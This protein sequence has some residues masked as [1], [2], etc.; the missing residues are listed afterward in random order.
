MNIK[1][2]VEGMTAPQVA[3]VIKDNFN[4]VDKDKA[5]KTDVNASIAKLAETVETN[6]TETD[7]KIDSNKEET[8]GK[9][10]ELGSKYEKDYEP[11]LIV[12]DAAKG[13]KVYDLPLLKDNVYVLTNKSSATLSVDNVNPSNYDEKYDIFGNCVANMQKELVPTANGK[14]AVYANG[15]NSFEVECLN[16]LYY[17]FMQSLNKISA[18]AED[19]KK[20]LREGVNVT[21]ESVLSDANMAEINKI[22]LLSN[23]VANTPADY[24][25]LYSI[26]QGLQEYVVQYL[27]TP[28]STLYYRVKWREWRPWYKC[29]TI[30]IVL[31]TFLVHTETG[32]FVGTL[33]DGKNAQVGGSKVNLATG[34]VGNHSC[35]VADVQGGDTLK[36]YCTWTGNESYGCGWIAT[37][38]NGNVVDKFYGDGNGNGYLYAIMPD[39]ASKIY[40]NGLNGLVPTAEKTT[41]TK[42]LDCYTREEVDSKLQ[43]GVGPNISLSMFRKFGVVGDSYAS[44]E[45]YWKEGSEWKSKDKY[46]ISWGQIL[47][48]KHG[49]E[50]TN[51]SQGGLSTRTWLYSSTVNG[52]TKML[53]SEAEDLYILALGIN[54]YYGLGE[55]YLGTINDITTNADTFYGNYGQI[56]EQIKAHAPYAKLILFTCAGDTEIVQKFNTAIINIANHYGIPHIVQMEDSFFSSDIYNDMVQGH[57]RGV[58]YCGMANAFD[59]LINDC[60]KNNYVY[61]KDLYM[62]SGD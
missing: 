35:L 53:N 21:S 9:L 18:N 46:S 30:D 50:C 29:S 25:V 60:L 22:Y 16:S 45:V 17:K 40:V 52:L 56:I 41:T 43:K 12:T 11:T 58:A 44:G 31:P 6:K 37:D 28:N 39:N 38:A 59:R 5:N 19:I 47:A 10:S 61:F 2:I 15:I 1:E 57:P 54:D 24:G 3:Q 20:C 13:Y 36:V 23:K 14:F 8:D 27:L 55:S 26:S 7:A 33:N 4:E 62:N 51:Y 49:N 48:R 32:E 34:S 42:H